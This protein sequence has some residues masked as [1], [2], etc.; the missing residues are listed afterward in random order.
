MGMRIV[1]GWSWVLLPCAVALIVSCTALAPPRVWLERRPAGQLEPPA[2]RGPGPSRRGESPD[3]LSWHGALALARQNNPGLAAARERVRVA[4]ARRAEARSEIFPRV[5][6]RGSWIRFIEAADFRGRTTSNVSGSTTRTNFFTGRGSDIYTGGVDLSLSLFDGGETYHARRAAEEE[7]QAT[8]SD[9]AAAEY[10]MDLAV[11]TAFLDVLLARGAVEIARESL[12]FSRE[13]EEVARA[14]ADAGEGL[15]V[16]VLRFATR[17]SERQLALNRAIATARIRREILGELL[18]V[19]ID[20][21]VEFVEPSGDLVLPAGSL[22]E[23]ALRRRAELVALDARIAARRERVGQEK[24]TWWPS[25]NVFGS[26]GFISL[27][28]LALGQE[29]DEFQVGAALSMNLFE[30]GASR[31][32]ILARQSELADLV[33]QRRQLALAVEREV[34]EAQIDLDVVTKNVEVSRETLELAGEVLERVTARYRAG[35][36]QILD[37]TE[38]ELERFG[39]RLVYL[40]SWIHR[41]L[42]QARLGRAV[43]SGIWVPPGGEAPEGAPDDRRVDDPGGATER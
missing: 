10:D 22:V 34:R 23:T 26:Y 4:L 2:L 8:R 25:L 9:T 42:A 40:R 11:S 35:E 33:E 38:A 7:V 15:G 17:A 6:L 16:D 12:Q 41:L 39:A 28:D 21:T 5:D 32:R 19:P 27:D 31:A 43:G 13:Q 24:A 37:V 1:W 29:K 18:G 3:S 36:A 14:R 30:G 20:E